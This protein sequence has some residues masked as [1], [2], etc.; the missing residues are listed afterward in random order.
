[1]GPDQLKGVGFE[2][3][4]R[5]WL[6]VR[7]GARKGKELN[8]WGAKSAA[9]GGFAVVIGSWVVKGMWSWDLG[10][11]KGSSWISLSCTLTD[12]KR[13]EDGME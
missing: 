8:S 10:C 9:T 6:T 5:G 7:Q 3:N 4:P 11:D 12:N 13:S 2:F 1:M